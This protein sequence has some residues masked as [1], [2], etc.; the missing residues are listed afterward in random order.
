MEGEYR[1]RDKNRL[2]DPPPPDSYVD[3][4]FTVSNKT[5]K[6]G[7]F[8]KN[9]FNILQLYWISFNTFLKWTVI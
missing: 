4:T 8:T 9:R 1:I 3:L 2:N 5:F 6:F 7:S